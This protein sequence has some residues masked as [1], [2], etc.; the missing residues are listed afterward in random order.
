MSEDLPSLF[1][2]NSKINSLAGVWSGPGC[3]RQNPAE[4]RMPD[5]HELGLGRGVGDGKRS[6]VGQDLS[7]T[8]R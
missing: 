5:T 1:G 3:A 6:Y 7:P 8:R 2:I 4:L